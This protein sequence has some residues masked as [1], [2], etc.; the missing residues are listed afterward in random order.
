VVDTDVERSAYEYVSFPQ[1]VIDD[2]YIQQT[3]PM[4]CEAL[5]PQTQPMDYAVVMP[6]PHTMGYEVVP[7]TQEYDLVEELLKG[8]DEPTPEE[9]LDAVIRS[10]SESHEYDHGLPKPSA[11]AVDFFLK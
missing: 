5:V 1:T 11:S 3:Q 7:Q 10:F 2:Y 8:P 6:Q 4:D 9:E